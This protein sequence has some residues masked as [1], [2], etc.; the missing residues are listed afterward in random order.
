M[1]GASRG[2]RRGLLPHP[3]EP[4]RSRALAAAWS[5]LL[6]DWTCRGFAGMDTAH[7]CLHLRPPVGFPRHPTRPCGSSGADPQARARIHTSFMPG[8][9]TGGEQPPKFAGQQNAGNMG[10]NASLWNEEFRQR[11]FAT[12]R[13][14]I[15][16]AR[17]ANL[18]VDLARL[19]SW[20]Q[21]EHS[22]RC[23]LHIHPVQR[24]FA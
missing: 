12:S 17:A 2:G 6:V 7:A 10:A 8:A 21:G 20:L 13:V 5:P 24:P 1:K 15:R 14:V 11:I 22:P 19:I 3:Q 4:C 18:F 9:A 23:R 16:L